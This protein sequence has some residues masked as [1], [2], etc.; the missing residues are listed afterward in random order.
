MWHCP[1][2]I[3]PQTLLDQTLQFRDFW[4]QVYFM[5]YTQLYQYTA[6]MYKGI[7]IE[8]YFDA[9]KSR[10]TIVKVSLI[11]KDSLE[12]TCGAKI[13]VPKV[14][15]GQIFYHAIS[16]FK[17]YLRVIPAPKIASC[18]AHISFEDVMDDTKKIQVLRDYILQQVRGAY[19]DK[20]E[21]EQWVLWFKP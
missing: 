4:E 20:R 17:E 18:E 10:V 12:C 21:G 6:V 5:P 15:R 11:Q 3:K 14:N 19:L 7:E 1:K 2:C 8:L 16:F 9:Y 13:K